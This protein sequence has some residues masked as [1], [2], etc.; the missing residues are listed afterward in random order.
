M[1][2]SHSGT[3][4]PSSTIQFFVVLTELLHDDLPVQRLVP[5]VRVEGQAGVRAAADPLHHLDQRLFIVRLAKC[6]AQ[7]YFGLDVFCQ[8]EATV[9]E[10]DVA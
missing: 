3:A 6:T 4:S 9:R 8:C 7:L 10:F 2:L 5:Q 1:R